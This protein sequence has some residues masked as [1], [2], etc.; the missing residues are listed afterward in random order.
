MA[1][2]HA[3][4]ACPLVHNGDVTPR[5]Q[6]LAYWQRPFADQ[7]R[8]LKAARLQRDDKWRELES[9]AIEWARDDASDPEPWVLMGTALTRMDR[10]PEAQRALDCSLAAGPASSVDGARL[11]LKRMPDSAVPPAP[12]VIG[13]RSARTR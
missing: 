10:L 8:F 7:P 4:S 1:R 6:Q 13:S 12:C 11:E 9:L 3:G 2:A 5:L